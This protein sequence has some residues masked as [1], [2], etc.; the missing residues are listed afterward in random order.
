MYVKL[1]LC[2]AAANVEPLIV[3]H[4]PAISGSTFFQGDILIS[5][6]DYQ[7]FFHLDIFFPLQI[8]LYT[9]SVELVRESSSE[10]R[11]RSLSYSEMNQS[12]III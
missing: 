6:L 8:R 9:S 5:Q 10:I 1:D 4:I 2:K 7:E 12:R 3:Y 11:K